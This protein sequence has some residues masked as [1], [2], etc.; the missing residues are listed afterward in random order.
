MRNKKIAAV[1]LAGSL[2][3]CS[4]TVYAAQTQSDA[5]GN[6]YAYSIT[7]EQTGE[8]DNPDDY[9]FVFEE[10]I[11]KDDV[12]YVL[13][14]IEY[15]VKNAY[16]EQYGDTE[17]ANTIC[18]TVDGINPEEKE[19]YKPEKDVIT[20]DD[21]SYEYKSTSFEKSAVS[22]EPIELESYMDTDYT[23]GEL[24]DVDKPDTI[25]LDYEGQT[26]T[27][28]YDHSEKINDGWKDGV[29]I[30]G[31]IYHYDASSIRFGDILIEPGQL[32]NIPL[33]DVQHYIEG[34]GY[35][36]DI[37]RLESVS[38]DGEAYTDDNGV[39][40]RD[41]IVHASVNT[42]QYRHYYTYNEDRT[43]YTAKNTYEL[44]QEDIQALEKLKNTHSVV[45]TAFYDEKAQ[46][47]PKTSLSLPAK[48]A[49]A[50]GVIVGI[51][52]II[53]L[54]LYLIKGGRKGTDYRSR[55]DSKR[56]FKNM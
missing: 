21:F 48:V 1:I 12:I 55:R 7:E 14:H 23:T 30:P 19:V 6:L 43:M 22:K 8:S 24:S 45:A 44:S 28:S 49:I 3:I 27:L 18:E 26:Y 37:Y 50:F 51:V 41:Y 25:Q 42:R 40:C 2:V 53:A 15:T 16:E 4:G 13:N 31:T 20:Q 56:D 52:L 47:Q 5:D 35:S 34:Y 9:D 54:I 32:T 36:P 46:A 38:Y 17:L 39:I 10:Q 29:S 33:Q 11:E